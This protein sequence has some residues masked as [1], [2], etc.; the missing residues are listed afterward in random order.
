MHMKRVCVYRSFNGNAVYPMYASVPFRGHPTFMYVM[1]LFSFL[2]VAWYELRTRH[3]TRKDT[4]HRYKQDIP[5][6]KTYT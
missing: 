5:M 3:V 4:L 2:F 6:C 1:Y